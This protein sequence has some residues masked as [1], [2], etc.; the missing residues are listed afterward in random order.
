MNLREIH[1]V[2]PLTPHFEKSDAFLE[3][4]PAW[5][6]VT[7]KVDRYEVTRSQ[8]LWVLWFYMVFS[9]SLTQFVT[10]TSKKSRENSKTAWK[11]LEVVMRCDFL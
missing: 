10:W 7:L 5:R 2:H 3:L 8:I 9:L 11:C 6:R 4:R 1:A